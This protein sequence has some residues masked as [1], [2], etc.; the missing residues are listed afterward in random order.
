MAHSRLGYPRGNY[1][2]NTDTSRHEDKVMAN[3]RRTLAPKQAWMEDVIIIVLLSV[4]ALMV[5]TGGY[6]WWQYNGL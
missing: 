4:T 2:Y 6:V 1:Y 5:A 3:G